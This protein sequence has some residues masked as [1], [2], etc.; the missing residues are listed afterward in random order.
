MS[1]LEQSSLPRVSFKQDMAY[2]GV[3][4]FIVITLMCLNFWYTAVSSRHDKEYIRIAGE[5]RILSQTISQHATSAID[6]IP[7]AFRLLK[8][9]RDDFAAELNVLKY[10]DVKLGL[11]ASINQIQSN[12]LLNV[13]GVWHF[14]KDKTDVLLSQNALLISLSEIEEKSSKIVSEIHLKLAHLM[15][16]MSRDDRIALQSVLAAKQSALIERIVK[17]MT[18]IILKK[19][20]PTQAAV[21]LKADM[22]F[23]SEQLESMRRGANT[24]VKNKL[25][26]ISVLYATLSDNAKQLLDALVA[27]SL[28]QQASYDIYKN[29]QSLLDKTTI[30]SNA[31]ILDAEHRFIGEPTG[32][33][34]G[35]T[36]LLLLIWL[37][38][39]IITD[40]KEALALAAAQHKVNRAAV[41]LLLDELE[42]LANGDLTVHTTT[43]AQMTS[44]I[45][46][47]VN[48][49]ID[50]LR[51]LVFTIN[52]TAV[53]VSNAAQKVQSTTKYLEQASENQS[54]EIVGVS[55]AV[56]A[57]ATSAQ[58]VA[59]HAIESSQVAQASVVTAQSGVSIVN[60]TIVGMEDIRGQIQETAKKIKKLGESTQE[61]GEIVSLINDITD[62][63]NILALNA[64][65]QAAM[66]G[67]AG[68]G[69]A[70]VAQEVQ[71]LAERSSKATRQIEM[72]VNA[73]QSDTNET[74]I[75]MEQT[76]Q[77]VV[78]GTT[79]AKDAG[80]ALEKIEKVSLDL[81]ELIQKISIA[82]KEQVTTA[83]KVSQTMNVIQEITTQ[84]TI[85]T[86]ET[87]GSIGAL[88][89][90]A[91]ELRD[92]VTGFKLPIEREQERMKSLDKEQQLA[93]L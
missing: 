31:Y 4:V 88:A 35:A 80:I 92:S 54:G 30:L 81:R 1:I 34:L 69:F 86:H 22:K 61:I 62:Q 64:S 40:T 20:D 46:E 75:S 41:L 14:V 13:E 18:K 56:N 3:L 89:E 15:D 42:N 58:Q 55:I 68:K 63:T 51:R 26:E 38:Y 8:K 84:T 45:A 70:V 21:A 25:L 66:A 57:M 37:G 19:E 6:G 32:Y 7:D 53:Q 76:T 60:N 47:S 12:E 39:R 87:A 49:A 79:L 72:L 85:G 90:L 77:E 10:G 67:E 52:D 11:P 9:S 29:S 74:I 78:V 17:N 91:I 65:I 44:A 93:A 5:L 33:M 43:G 73:I 50:A 36:G 27:F 28:I 59:Q 71:R 48:S 82:A 2:I 23:F 24:E 16:G 83:S